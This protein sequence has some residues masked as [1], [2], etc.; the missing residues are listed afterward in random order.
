MD[1]ELMGDGGDITIVLR[2][3]VCVV[4]VSNQRLIYI[5]LKTHP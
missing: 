2:G 1:Y 5:F 3:G 4:L